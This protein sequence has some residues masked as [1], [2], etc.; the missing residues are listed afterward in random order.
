MIRLL[1]KRDADRDYAGVRHRWSAKR[2]GSKSAACRS[3]EPAVFA[4]AIAMVS[5]SELQPEE[6]GGIAERYG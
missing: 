6:T 4:A 5:A 2:H 3:S 1:Q